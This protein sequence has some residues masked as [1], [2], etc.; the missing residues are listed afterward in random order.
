VQLTSHSDY[1]LRVL[2]YLLSHP[3]QNV[4]TREMAS[5]YGISL[6]HLTKVAKSLCRGGWLV[7][8]RGSGGG[9]QLAA[10]TPEATV[11]EVIRFTENLDLLEC[12]NPAK[13]TCPIVRAC[14]L[15]S[16]LYKARQAFFAVLD[17]YKVR[18]LARN[19]NELNAL[20]LPAG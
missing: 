20:F 9:L 19:P 11:G 8:A 7:Y 5:A 15:R 16:V 10:H 12:F 18:D 17:S 6:N 14:E 1:A 3:G 2:I 4:S 13:N